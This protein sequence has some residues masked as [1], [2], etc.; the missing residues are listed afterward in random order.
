M[1]VRSQRWLLLM[2]LVTTCVGSELND[3]R[4][5]GPESCIRC[6]REVAETQTKTA[7]ANTWHGALAPSIPKPLDLKKSEGPEPSLLY[8]VRG[9][10]TGF[11]FVVTMP[12]AVRSVLP[13]EAMIGGTR[14]GLSFLQRIEQVDGIP[15]ERSALIEAR[16]AYSPHG[17]LVLSPGFAIEKPS[18][19]EDALGRVLSPRFERRC[20]ACHG[21]PGT[22]GAGKLGGVRCESCHGAAI[23]H[24]NAV[25]GRT[26]QPS[27]IKPSALSGAES[28]NVCAQCHTG[29]SNQS[30]PL[31]DDL[32]VSSQ[33][34]ALRNS[35]C[36][37]QSSKKLTCV[38]CHNPHQ[39]S[40]NVVETSVKTCLSCHSPGH[41]G[42]ASICPINATSDCIR[43]HMPSI[44]KNSFHLTDHWIRVHP[45]Q[46]M[47]AAKSDGNLASHIAP[48][49]EFLRIIAVD[50]LEK[51]HAVLQR[52]T[53]GDAFT[54]VARQMSIDPTAPA[55]GYIGDTD[56]LQMDPKL[57]AAAEKLTYN[58]TSGAIELGDRYIVL[59]RV[60]RDF[61]WQADQLFREASTLKEH[62]DRKGALEKDQQALQI[63]PYFLRA[64]VLMGTTLG[65]G[66][67][68]ERASQIL[69][70]AVQSY[71]KDASA[72]FDLGLTL[73]ARPSEQI[74]AFRHAIDLDP[75]T[76]AIYQSL[77]AA[78]Y[79]SG[80][81]QAAID[82]FRQGL[83][84]DPL[85]AILNYDLGLAMQQQGD[86][87]GA[88]RALS[89][90]G[91][92]DPEIA[93]KGRN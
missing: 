25:T 10:V 60:S 13:V 23:D 93:A 83:K 3:A 33:V 44:N 40:P 71:P 75:D 51:A 7:M 18:D 35:E 30:D 50:N 82:T 11:Q 42:H 27:T 81:P 56:L 17:A 43:C 85:S 52:L 72:E 4:Y 87:A 59:H 39:D 16:Y 74:E 20:L 29:L 76:I 57:S 14:H 69:R 36:F 70:F 26:L 58:G 66:G 32:L 1:G 64:L 90:A 41:Q 91:K 53:K 45:K 49:R 79:S 37:I 28:M 9:L 47:V 84:I 78:L 21:Q 22:L 46:A 12:N 68:T 19:Y 88:K 8:E 54:E 61:K 31:P 55:G 34:P 67:D 86:E 89:L 38:S 80:Q 6:H 73:A 77:G 62:G 24:V 63:Y 15:L 65:E 92:L 48:K 2:V 5:A